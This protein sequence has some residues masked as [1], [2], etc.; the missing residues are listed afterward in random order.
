MA[1]QNQTRETARK[2]MQAHIKASRA[3]LNNKTAGLRKIA[4]AEP[5]EVGNALEELAGLFGDIAEVFKGIAGDFGAMKEN[6][7]LNE[8]GKTA[9]IR[10]RISARRNYARTLRRLANEEPEQLGEALSIVY[11]QIDEAVQGIEAMAERFGLPLD[12]PAEDMP[13]HEDA[14]E[15]AE[16]AEETPA[17]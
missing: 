15:D 5:H 16:I 13:N 14:A 6:L 7:D 12:E 2:R 9:S 4:E 1:N 17:L 11:G 3:K 8:P 10:E